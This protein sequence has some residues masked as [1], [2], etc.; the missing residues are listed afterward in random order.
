MNKLMVS[1]GNLT[2]VE[3]AFENGDGVLVESEDFIMFAVKE[4][5]IKFA[6][7]QDR[8]KKYYDDY[9]GWNVL[10]TRLLENNIAQIILRDKYFE[11]NV[12]MAD[13]HNEYEDINKNQDTYINEFGNLVC[14]VQYDKTR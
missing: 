8:N 12:I 3:F 7:K 2:S 11:K 9:T 13:W 4:D 5:K 14:E 1:L 6:I 10:F